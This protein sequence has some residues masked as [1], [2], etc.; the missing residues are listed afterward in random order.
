MKLNLKA[1]L[2]VSASNCGR[3]IIHVFPSFNLGTH[4]VQSCVV[5]NCSRPGT[6]NISCTFSNSSKAMGYLSVLSSETNRSREMFVVACRDDMYSSDLKI[7]VSGVRPDKY[8]VIVYDIE[9]D[10]LPVLSNETNSSFVLCAEEKDVAVI[11]EPQATTRK[12]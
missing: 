8:S 11:T 12:K 1:K 3:P 7:S 10:G 5:N 6:V 2:S 9:S 4:E